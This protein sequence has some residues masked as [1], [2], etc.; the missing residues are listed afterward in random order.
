MPASSQC[1]RYVVVPSE[2]KL[3]FIA[4]SSLHPVKGSANELR[5]RVEAGWSDGDIAP[6]PPPLMHVEFAVE[7][8][9]SGNDMQDRQMWK[10]LDSKR[11]PRVVADLHK[12][13]PAG[14]RRYAASGDITL[15]GK[16][17]RYTGELAVTHDAGRVTVDGRLPLDIRDFGLNPPPFFDVHRRAGGRGATAP[18]RRR[19]GRFVARMCLAIPGQIVEMDAAQPLLAKVDVAGVRRNVNVGLFEQSELSPGDWILI[20]VGFALSKIG[21]EEARDQLRMLRAMGEDEL[22]IEEVRGYAFDAEGAAHGAAGM[23]SDEVRR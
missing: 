15:A 21:E 17:R 1:S 3:E 20:H 2:T 10:L 16:T 4:S 23:V 9:R 22:A 12:L 6:D 5:G 13:R 7:Q 11:N 14:P 19:S 8:L 18:G